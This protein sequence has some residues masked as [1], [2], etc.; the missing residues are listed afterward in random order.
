MSPTLDYTN[1]ESPTVFK[2]DGQRYCQDVPCSITELGDT[3]QV[4]FKYN[5]TL[6][7]ELK[8]FQG[9]RWNP[10]K[11]LWTVANTRRNWFQLAFLAGYD[12]YGWYDQPLREV[13]FGPRKHWNGSG[14]DYL[15]PYPHQQDLVKHGFTYHFGIW[16]AEMGTGKSLASIYV[17]ELS[18][19][20]NEECLYVGPKSALASFQLQLREWCS[21]ITPHCVTYEGLK[22][23][24]K[25]WPTGK[26]A[27]KLVIFDESSRLKNPT[28]QR[29]QAAYHLAESMRNEWGDECFVILMSGSP[30]PKSPADWWW[31]AEIACPGFIKEGTVEKFKTRLGLIV[32]RE[33]ITG[34]T[35]PHLIT[36]KD[37]ERKCAK[38]GQ[39][40]SHSDHG[41]AD[42]FSSMVNPT[43][44]PFEKS[45]NEVSYLYERMKGLTEVKFKKDC[46]SLPDKRYRI[47]ECKPSIQTLNAAKIIVAGAKTTISGLTLLRE[48]SDGFQ[49]TEEPVGEI[50]CPTCKGLCMVE[51]HVPIV[52][53]EELD[54][55][56]EE[57]MEKAGEQYDLHLDNNGFPI[58]EYLLFPDKYE[59]Q[60]VPCWKCGGEGHVTQ[61]RTETAQVKCPK[62]DA[63]KEILDSH[64]EDGRLVT[65]AGFQ[66]SV[67]R[68]CEIHSKMGWEW[69]K[70]DGRGWT[71]SEKVR[72][73]RKLNALELLTLF[74]QGQERFPRLGFIGQPSSA[75]MGLTLTAACEI[76]YWSNDFNAESRV[77]SEDRIHRAGMNVNK[78]ALIT[79]LVH[80]PSDLHVLE[81]LRK[82]R[83]LQDMSLG[84]F[85]DALKSMSFDTVR[86]I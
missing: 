15:S 25:H 77:Q 57:L 6:V 62:E 40:E 84:Q 16:A 20:T 33:S 70:V 36:W 50:T 1:I 85:H 37:D 12:T 58:P 14:Y 3:L 17:M 54:K 42:D 19:L 64:E 49:Y 4:K 38:C 24:V 43:I 8:S 7:T 83:R 61:Y 10:D 71:C 52:D 46:L 76:C 80:L 78:G 66:G 32:Q 2:V 65:Y 5:K 29:S 86:R 75:G 13:E 27:P 39:L 9:A 44:H 34:G 55:A 72:E 53:Q 69:I 23:L 11:K 31:Q 79:D 82:K 67:D 59:L 28:S 48:L 60:M 47:I 63:L 21:E 56:I 51:Q 73:R 35:Y 81:N 45:V 30:A 74:Q 22:S 41:V 26:P 68:V 18:K